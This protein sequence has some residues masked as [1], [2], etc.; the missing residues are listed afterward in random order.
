MEMKDYIYREI[1]PHV[2]DAQKIYPV[3]LVSG[4]RQVGKSTL[5]RQL[6]PEYRFVNLEDPSAK[7]FAAADP[8]GFL[9]AL[10]TNAVID[11]AQNCPALLS[12]IQAKVDLNQDNRYILTGSSD[13]ALMH[14]ACQSLAGRVALFTLPPLS[15]SEVGEGRLDASTDELV[16]RGFFPSVL[17]KGDTPVRFYRNYYA[18]YIEKDV[19]SLLKVG[20][21]GNFDTFVRLLAG[22]VGTESNASAL[23]SEVG[24]SSNTITEW[25]SIL[26]ASYIIFP[27]RPYF[28]NISKR[29]S[30]MP[31]WYFYDTGL[32][33]YLLGIE[34]PRHIAYHPLR[35]AL[36]E[37]MVVAE[38]VKKYMNMARDPKLYFYRENG[39]REVDILRQTATG[40]EAFE[41][42]SAKT[43]NSA[44]MSNMKYLD[45]VLPESAVRS[46]VIYD[47]TAFPPNLI[48]VRDVRG[49]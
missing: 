17:A 33:A 40:I 39:G 5:C 38:F 7:S 24:V 31:K 48:N 25:T 42:K 32:A 37:N 26:A 34:D 16:C 6:F 47:G 20:N 29:L 14:T 1:T 36:F 10:G 18:T 8:N 13:F 30:K 45:K 21:L 19:R 43:F 4:A 11:E 28:A 22:R 27:L 9:D 2:L 3:T 23:S 12:A 35:G 41:I 49:L 15:F 46:T 44:F